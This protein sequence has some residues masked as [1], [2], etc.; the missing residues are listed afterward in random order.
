[1]ETAN[2]LQIVAAWENGSVTTHP[3]SFWG[4]KLPNRSRD[5]PVATFVVTYRLPDVDT[6][7]EIIAGEL[8]ERG[9]TAAS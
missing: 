3:F 2:S 4:R 1:M 6:I 7:M 9:W 5:Y 8:E